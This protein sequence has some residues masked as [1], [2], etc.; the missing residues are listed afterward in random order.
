MLARFCYRRLAVYYKRRGHPR[1]RRVRLALV[2]VGLLIAIV[3]GCTGQPVANQSSS[4][5]LASPSGNST[6]EFNGQQAYQHALAQCAIG[7]RSAG[8]A[9][10]RQTADYIA[11]QLKQ[12]NW[13]VSTQAFDFRGTPIKNVIGERGQG[14][15]VILGAHFDTRK[16]ASSDPQDQTAPVP[17]GNDGASGVAVL[18]ELA[19]VWSQ[20]DP[21]YTIQLAFFDAEDNGEIDGWPWSVGASHMANA[22]TDKPEFVLVVDMIGDAD[23]QIYMERNSD[24][25]LQQA[26]WKVAAELGY[27]QQFVTQYKWAVTDDHTPFLQRGFRAVD[28]IDFDYS[29]WHTTQDTCDKVS[30]ES[31]ARVG[32]VLDHF[33]QNQANNKGAS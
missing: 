23:Q 32:T 3:A 7:P 28:L 15:L 22:L 9:G 27:Q 33:L 17:G 30:P 1:R 26:I 12:L 6:L 21:G 4:Q 16:F 11:A 24:P 18:L 25:A 19:R 20:R 29:Y 14:P 5:S 13:Q 10:D 8:T 31:L 2:G